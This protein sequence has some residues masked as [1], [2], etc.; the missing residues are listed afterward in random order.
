MAENNFQEDGRLVYSKNHIVSGWTNLLAAGLGAAQPIA[1]MRN[2]GP[3]EI[4]VDGVEMGFVTTTLATAASTLAFA[5]YKVPGFTALG[6]GNGRATP[7]LPVRKR[8]SDH[9]VLFPSNAASVAAGDLGPAHDTFLEVQ[10]SDTAALSGIT[11]SPAVV[12][13]DPQD[14]LICRTVLAATTPTYLYEGDSV[15]TPKQR[16]PL[17]LGPN[18]GLIFQTLQAF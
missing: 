8:N 3:A 18:E 4:V 14:V 1:A 17:T 12:T 2:V 15:W 16:V 5:F 6:A 7:P 11:V 9:R 13:G 10:I